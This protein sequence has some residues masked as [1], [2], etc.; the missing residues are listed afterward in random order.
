MALQVSF[1]TQLALALNS[2]LIKFFNVL[3]A[4]ECLPRDPHPPRFN[5]RNIFI[6]HQ[7][8]YLQL[9]QRRGQQRIETAQNFITAI[10]QFA[11]SAH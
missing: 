5:D 3:L 1:V 2:A 10:E 9:M 8:L 4:L 7:N 6:T 11:E